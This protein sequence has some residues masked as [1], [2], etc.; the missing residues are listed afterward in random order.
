MSP[1]SVD[2]L[3]VE[4]FGPKYRIFAGYILTG[5]TS[6]GSI[7]LGLVAYYV[8]DWR[9]LQLIISLPMFPILIVT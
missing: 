9:T 3:G 7:L 8:R 2:L 6:I 1:H 5:V 4:T